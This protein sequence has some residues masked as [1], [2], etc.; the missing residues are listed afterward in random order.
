MPSGLFCLP[1]F[2]RTA[3]KTGVPQNQSRAAAQ[4]QDHRAGGVAFAELRSHPR[5]GR[6]P[7]AQGAFPA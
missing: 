6:A 2:R 1:A 5:E 7:P 4:A 3:H